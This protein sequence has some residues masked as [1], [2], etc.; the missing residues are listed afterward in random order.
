MESLERANIDA[1]NSL[2]RTIFN[3]FQEQ[4]CDLNFHINDH[5][6]VNHSIEHQVSCEAYRSTT[7]KASLIVNFIRVCFDRWSCQQI[8]H[9]LSS[10]SKPTDDRGLGHCTIKMTSGRLN[11]AKVKS[12]VSGDTLVLTNLNDPSKEMSL[13]LAFV[14]APRLRRDGDEVGKLISYM[15]WIFYA[16]YA[17]IC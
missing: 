12:V 9:F 10:N 15:K 16:R 6:L 5:S 2:P 17:N 7:R 1:K 13:S 8:F 4:S 3:P 11:Q 14:S